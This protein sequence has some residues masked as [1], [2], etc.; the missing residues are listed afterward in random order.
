[1]R[2][3]SGKRQVGRATP[4]RLRAVGTTRWKQGVPPHLAEPLERALAAA[5]RNEVGEALKWFGVCADKC[6]GPRDPHMKPI[7][8]FGA[9]AASSAYF[10]LRGAGQE[11]G[12]TVVDEWRACAETLIRAAGELDPG[13]PVAAHNV[14]RFLHGCDDWDAAVAMYRIALQLKGTQVESWANLGTAYANQGDRDGARRCWMKATAFAPENPSGALAQSYIWLRAGDY[15]KGWAA[16]EHRWNDLE[17]K[18]GYGRE[19]ELT[20]TRWMGEALP[21]GATL[22]VHGEQGLGDHVQFARFV[23]A[24]VERGIRIVGLETRPTLVRWMEGA[25]PGLPIV[26]R[27]GEIPQHT[28]HVSSMSLPNILGLTLDTVPPPVAPV[29]RT[30]R[31]VNPHHR[32]RVALAWCGA[33]GNPADGVRSIPEHELA[34]LRGIDVDWVSVQFTPLAGMIARSYLGND[35]TDA[36]QTCRDVFDTA[37]VMAG[38]DLVVCVDTLTAHL[39]GSLGLPT[40][41]LQRFDREWRWGDA[42]T[43]DERTPWYPSIRQ[44]TQTAPSDWSGPIDAVRRELGG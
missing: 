16:F 22:F 6:D 36:S 11:V 33:A 29:V 40:L 24:L 4:G 3:K 18:R 38:C 5:E 2:A 31:A 15:T 25:L 10:A 35:V 9:Q 41:L 12:Q 19:K 17:F 7:V 8:Y 42:A 37:E 43:G 13:D 20:G 1:M 34:R 28:H 21:K 23:P 32:K 30:L 44:L 27:G 26:P 39:A 14:G